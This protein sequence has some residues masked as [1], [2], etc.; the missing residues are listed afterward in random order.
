MISQVSI[1]RPN[2]LYLLI[3]LGSGCFVSLLVH[4]NGELARYSNVYHSTWAAHATGSLAALAL[5]MVFARGRIVGPMFKSGAPVWAYLGGFFGA[6][7]T[8][9][10]TFAVNSTISL[11]GTL[12][13]V[14]TGQTAFG[15][16]A[17][18]WGLF[19]LKRRSLERREYIAVG[20]ILT[21]NLMII[22]A[23]PP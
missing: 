4:F 18:R 14:L 7:I 6:F 9:L 16:A 10:T 1:L 12:A 20:L 21:G 19:G 11:S 5:L 2:P 17:D 8:L 22:L 13:L 3:P 23:G 15:L